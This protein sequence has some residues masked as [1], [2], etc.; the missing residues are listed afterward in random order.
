LNASVEFGA[1]KREEVAKLRTKETKIKEVRLER[2][3][4]KSETCTLSRKMRKGLFEALKGEVKKAYFSRKDTDFVRS[5]AT[6][7]WCLYSVDCMSDLLSLSIGD[8]W[9]NNLHLKPNLPQ[10]I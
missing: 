4:W 8:P 6:Q 2:H 7:P 5:S 1:A 9:H 3:I 10:V